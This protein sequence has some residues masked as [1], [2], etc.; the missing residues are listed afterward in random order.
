MPAEEFICVR[1]ARHQK[2]CCQTYEI[3]TTLGDEERIRDFTGRDSFT[4]F[5]RPGDPAYADQDDDP[6]WRDFVFREDGSRRVLTRQPNGDC[7][8]LC[9]RGCVLPLEVRPLICR[10]YPYDYTSRGIRQELS[11]G[12][13]LE[14]LSPGQELIEALDMNLE[15]ARRWHRQLYQE[16]QN[17]VHD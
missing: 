3:Y 4:E 1:C 6:I 11:Q 7:T 14:L 17:E 8:F 16:V 2:T 5:C 9:Q 15:D 10:I 12:C 13:P